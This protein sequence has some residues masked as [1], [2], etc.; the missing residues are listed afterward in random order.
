MN[1]NALN[2]SHVGHSVDWVRWV[3]IASACLT[4]VIA[5]AVFV[6]ALQQWRTNRQQYRL[7]L[8]DKRMAVFD[9]VRKLIATSLTQNTIELQNLY[10]L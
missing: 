8:F 1:L 10:Q 3:P 5:I 7:A 4:P 2:W 9:G 6:V